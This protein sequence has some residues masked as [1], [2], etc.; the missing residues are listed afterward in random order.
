[1]ATPEVEVLDKFFRL[2]P[3]FYIWKN[4]LKV[5]CKHLLKIK[6]NCTVRECTRLWCPVSQILKISETW[7][8][9]KMREQ[10]IITGRLCRWICIYVL[11]FD[12]F[13]KVVCLT[14]R[15]DFMRKKIKVKGKNDL[16]WNNIVRKII[17][18]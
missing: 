5:L 3:K 8:H 4:R 18:F 1:M 15:V 16:W 13:S 11:D 17:V 7:H 9:K 14:L 2:S 10:K 6:V 12:W